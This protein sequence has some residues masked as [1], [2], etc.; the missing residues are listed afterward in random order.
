VKANTETITIDPT[1]TA[2]VSDQNK[3]RCAILYIFLNEQLAQSLL[4]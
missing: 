2:I 4:L 3:R 1:M